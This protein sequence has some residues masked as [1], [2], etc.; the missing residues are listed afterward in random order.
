M[1]AKLVLDSQLMQD[2]VQRA[3]RALGKGTLD[4]IVNDTYSVNEK[5]AIAK[6]F[7]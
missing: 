2:K 3:M 4:K 5:A 6:L 7:N 1:H